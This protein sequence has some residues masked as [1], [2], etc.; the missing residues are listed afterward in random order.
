MY[1]NKEKDSEEEKEEKAQ[2]ENF[3]AHISQ[4]N[5]FLI[6]CIISNGP[7]IEIKANV[8][9]T[10]LSVKIKV[11]ILPNDNYLLLS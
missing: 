11:R 9:E 4:D 6:K 3:P 8:T 5:S 10:V 7:V 2:Q 1:T